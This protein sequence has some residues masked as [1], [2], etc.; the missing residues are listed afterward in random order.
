VISV[1]FILLTELAV[2]IDTALI[3]LSVLVVVGGA[4]LVSGLVVGLLVVGFLLDVGSG[5]RNRIR[6]AGSRLV[7]VVLAGLGSTVGGGR[8]RVVRDRS[9]DTHARREGEGG[10]KD[11]EPSVRHPKTFLSKDPTRVI[12]W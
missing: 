5:S 2:L 11:T 6:R 10:E 3:R 4:V 7:I 8:G 12:T 9:A 1:V